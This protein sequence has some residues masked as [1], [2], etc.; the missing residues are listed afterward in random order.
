MV[1][2]GKQLQKNKLKSK[3]DRTNKGEHLH[4]QARERHFSHCWQPTLFSPF[5]GV[6][7]TSFL[8]L[9]FTLSCRDLQ[10]LAEETGPFPSMCGIVWLRPA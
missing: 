1:S 7:L 5:D 4:L 9:G 2:G 8:C 3:K 10:T 6:A